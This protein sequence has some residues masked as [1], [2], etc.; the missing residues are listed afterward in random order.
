LAGLQLAGIG[1]SLAIGIV[2]GLIIGILIK[3]INTNDREDQFDDL[4]V[5]EP[6]FPDSMKHQRE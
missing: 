1:F 3:I 2:A 4:V 5:Y 6:D